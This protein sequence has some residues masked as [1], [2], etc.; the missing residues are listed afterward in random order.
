MY[1]ICTIYFSN[2]RNALRVVSKYFANSIV[3]KNIRIFTLNTL[4]SSLLKTIHDHLASTGIL[5]RFAANRC[6][7]MPR[8]PLRFSV[9]F[10]GEGLLKL[11]ASTFYLH[12]VYGT[13][14][15]SEV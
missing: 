11:I 2:I 12:D 9:W 4:K 8:I 1:F 15:R 14:F 7:T 3:V 13:I 5:V 6:T 10:V